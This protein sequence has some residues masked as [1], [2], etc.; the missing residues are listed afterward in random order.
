[1]T[2]SPRNRCDEDDDDDLDEATPT[3]N[4]TS[5]APRDEQ[6]RSQPPSADQQRAALMAAEELAQRNKQLAELMRGGPECPPGAL[7][8]AG[9]LLGPGGLHPALLG[10]PHPHLAQLHGLLQL[11]RSAPPAS[12]DDENGKH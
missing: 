12:H 11:K 5:S 10:H 2:W 1:M 9:G 6:T 8:V 4:N 7:G 3:N